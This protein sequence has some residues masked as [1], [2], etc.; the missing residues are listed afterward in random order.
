MRSWHTGHGSLKQLYYWRLGFSSQGVSVDPGRTC[1]G[2]VERCITGRKSSSQCGTIIHDR[3]PAT[4]N[5]TCFW[6]DCT[7]GVLWGCEL[8]HTW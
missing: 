6:K 7:I 1:T 2:Y 3:A 4:W 5:E 8:H